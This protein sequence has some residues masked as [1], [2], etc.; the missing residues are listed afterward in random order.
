MTLADRIVVMHGGHIQQQGTPAELFRRPANKFVA[1]FLGAP[2]M[3]F[4][5][6]G[7]GPRR[8]RVAPPPDKGF[9]LDLPEELAARARDQ[10][11]RKV[12]LGIRPSDLDSAPD[13]PSGQG[14]ELG[15]V[16]SEYVGAQSVPYL[17]LRRCPRDRRGQVRGRPSPWAKP[18]ASPCVPEGDAPF[19]SG[20]PRAALLTPSITTATGRKT[21]MLKILGTTTLAGVVAFA[22]AA[23][24]QE[25]PYAPYAGHDACG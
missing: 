13:A 18:C 12:T 11:L 3:N 19:R 22:G 2:P 10:A 20:R 1:G 15:V 25:G 4:S 9:A 14:V 5:G 6:G 21:D 8:G 16:V 7:S 23:A 24:A 17:R